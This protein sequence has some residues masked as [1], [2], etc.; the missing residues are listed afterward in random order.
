M[1]YPG[2]LGPC[3]CDPP[4][5][6]AS[7]FTGV[8]GRLR[9]GGDRQQYTTLPAGSNPLLSSAAPSWA[10]VVRDGVS[11][12]SQP[13]QAA[14]SPREEFF[15]LHELCITTGFTARVTIHSAAGTQESSLSC[16]VRA[17]PSSTCPMPP[18]LEYDCVRC[19]E[20]RSGGCARS[21]CA[22]G[23]RALAGPEH[24]PPDL[25]PAKQT[26]KVVKRRGRTV[27]ER[28]GGGYSPSLSSPRLASPAGSITP[29]NAD[30]IPR[31]CGRVRYYRPRKKAHLCEF[32]PPRSPLRQLP[33]QQNSSHLGRLLLLR[34]PRL[35]PRARMQSRCSSR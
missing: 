14:L 1:A 17:P 21:D 24:S 4:F 23:L 28:G 7:R 2:R 34:H 15:S 20:P 9:K 18:P 30:Y 13:P 11:A 26:R 5:L 35:R 8:D 6:P 25:P 12:T 10:R 22:T 19:D 33:R 29:F 27:K 32:E 3:C 16:R 31:C